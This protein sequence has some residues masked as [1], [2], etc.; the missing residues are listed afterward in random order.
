MTS[1]AGGC[2]LTGCLWLNHIMSTEDFNMRKAIAMVL[3]LVIGI[4]GL[5]SC[6]LS[7]YLTPT[8][9]DKTAVTYAADAGV[10]DA[11]DYIGKWPNLLKA[12]SLQQA[13]RAAY[14]VNHLG[15]SQLMEK[16]ELDYRTLDEVARRNTEIGVAREE[17]AWGETGIV[18]GLLTAG[19]FGGFLGLL[20]LMRKRPGDLT[21]EDHEKALGEAGI[22]LKDRDRQL[23]EVVQGVKEFMDAGKPG[24]D[25]LKVALK[26]KTNSDTRTKIAALKTL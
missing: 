13:V 21:K 8:P 15:L 18:S 24:T 10:I 12:R 14:E 16:N 25:D 2:Q 20:G 4:M 11:N 9:I 22:E 23:L 5:G 19:G 7:E 26:G 3:L 1:A 17:I 6:V